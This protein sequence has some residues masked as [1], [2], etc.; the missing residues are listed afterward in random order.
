LTFDLI[1]SCLL[2]KIRPEPL[3][4]FQYR[5]QQFEVRPCRLFVSGSELLTFAL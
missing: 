4:H 3:H 1:R 2:R 5:R